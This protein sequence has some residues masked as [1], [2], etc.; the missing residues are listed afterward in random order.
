MRTIILALALILG[1]A[2]NVSASMHTATHMY[3]SSMKNNAVDAINIRTFEEKRITVGEA[4]FP[5]VIHGEM[6][7]VV[8]EKSNN[9]SVLD[10]NLNR[11]TQTIPVGED[12]RPMVIHGGVGYVVTWESNDVSVLDLQTNRVVT[13]FKNP[14]HQRI[15]FSDTHVYLGH[16]KYRSH[17]PTLASINRAK[18]QGTLGDF[19]KMMP[20]VFQLGEIEPRLLPKE[21]NVFDKLP[22]YVLAQGMFWDMNPDKHLM[23]PKDIL[24]TLVTMQSPQKFLKGDAGAWLRKRLHMA[25]FQTVWL[26]KKDKAKAMLTYFV[27]LQDPVITKLAT[28]HFKMGAKEE[29]SF[30]DALDEAPVK[31]IASTTKPAVKKVDVK[32]H[33]KKKSKKAKKNNKAK[34]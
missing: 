7:Y 22:P 14:D 3:I 28:Y 5:I 2:T 32:K 12:P 23:D 4:P 11:V 1:L 33:T 30:K 34:K 31:G 9:V 26:G 17:Y 27:Q 6:G 18:D 20:K 19:V 29:G 21:K 24:A 10:L 8:N 16:K 25:F 13:T 15:D